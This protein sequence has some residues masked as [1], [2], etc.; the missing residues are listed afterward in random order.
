MIRATAQVVRAARVC[1]N[2][3][4]P[5]IDFDGKLALALQSMRERAAGV[6][7]TCS[8]FA[9]VD[10]LYEHAQQA[11][12]NPDRDFT[13]PVADQCGANCNWAQNYTTDAYTHGLDHPLA[14][15]RDLREFTGRT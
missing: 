1:R 15:L 8:E 14:L 6:R 10:A 3:L 2:T 4:K 5:H 12:S 9:D 7:S 13:V 11:W